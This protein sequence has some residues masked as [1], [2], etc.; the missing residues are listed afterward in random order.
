MHELGTAVTDREIQKANKLVHLCARVGQAAG[1]AGNAAWFK[2]IEGEADSLT[3]DEQEAMANLKS[4]VKCEK[5]GFHTV[6]EESRKLERLQKEL[7]AFPPAVQEEARE[8]LSS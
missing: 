4:A 2:A 7:E 1:N 3:P 5:F 8:A 6:K